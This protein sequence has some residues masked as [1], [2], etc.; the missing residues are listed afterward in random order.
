MGATSFEYQIKSVSMGK[1]YE[2]AYSN[3]EDMS[4]SDPYNGTIS[5][6]DGY[7]DKTADFKRSGLSIRDYINKHIYDCDKWGAAWGVEVK[8]PKGNSNK[9][10]S[11]VTN[12]VT[13]GAKKWVTYYVV[14]SF[15]TEIGAKE[16]KGDAIKVARAYTEKNQRR[17]NI[18]IEKRLVGS[19][20]T[21]ADIHYKSSKSESEGTYVFFGTAAC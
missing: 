5:T 8:A 17:T 11:T 1:A 13:Q 14:Y 3:A 10:K 2:D 19:N 12:Y 16:K 6:T 4:G 9:I 21:V 7:I 20:S 18:N 15:G